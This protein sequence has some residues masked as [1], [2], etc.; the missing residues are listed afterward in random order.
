MSYVVF[1]LEL[2]TNEFFPNIQQPACRR[3]GDLEMT[4]ALAFANRKR[5]EAGVSHV[6]MSS[7]VDGQV[8][9]SGVDTVS[10]DG[11]LPDGTDYTW[12][13]RRL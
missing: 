5:N 3:F 7:Q 10:D 1:W 11:K 6:T 9:R 13:K 2:G 4:S 12:K 8:G